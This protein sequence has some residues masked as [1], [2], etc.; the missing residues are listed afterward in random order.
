[1][2]SQKWEQ[3]AAA[4]Q[5]ISSE[6]VFLRSAVL[7]SFVR[8]AGGSNSFCEGLLFGSRTQHRTRAASSDLSTED[9]SAIYQVDT[10]ISRAQCT[11]T[12]QTFYDSQGSVDPEY[13]KLREKTVNLDVVGC[14]FFCKLNETFS[15]TTR[16]I[17][18]TKSLTRYLE[19]KNCDTVQ[20]PVVAVLSSH[21]LT[22]SGG[23][24][25]NYQLLNCA[26]IPIIGNSLKLDCAE[27]NYVRDERVSMKLGLQICNSENLLTSAEE[28]VARLGNFVCGTL[29]TLKQKES[30]ETCEKQEGKLDDLVTTLNIL[31]RIVNNL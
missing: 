12:S 23:L 2:K 24:S 8:F 21:A 16:Q 7:A 29:A 19:N 5:H 17:I 25:F 3:A 6:R 18:V 11:G 9:D 26:L 27:R 13:L 31:R 4:T 1:M 15:L 10:S 30:Q 22:G 14:F 28:S 20:K